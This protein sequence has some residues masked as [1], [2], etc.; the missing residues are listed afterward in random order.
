MIG[1]F[2]GDDLFVETKTGQKDTSQNLASYIEKPEMP[3][4]ESNFVGFF[5]Q[6]ILF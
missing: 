5:N 4:G 3:R 2:F 1:D 6:Y